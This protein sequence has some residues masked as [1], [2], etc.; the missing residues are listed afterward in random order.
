MDIFCRGVIPFPPLTVQE[1]RFWLRI[2]QEHAVFIEAGLPCD[3]VELKIE[4]RNFQTVFAEL[5]EQSGTGGDWQR[6]AVNAA[7]AV[8]AFFCFKRRILHC[9]AECRL[10]GGGLYPLFVDHLSREALYF[11]K[12]LRKP[13]SGDMHCLVDAA[14]SENIF[15]ARVVADHL[16]FVRGLV[17][18]AER[19]LVDEAR[20]LGDRF[21]QFNLQARDVA[22][23]VWHYRP[24]N[25]FIRFERDF[26]LAGQ[27][28]LAFA[29]AAGGHVARCDAVTNIPE[30]LADHVRREGEHFLAVLELIRVYLLG[31]GPVAQAEG[32][33]EDEDEE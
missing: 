16:K 4:A 19:G 31:G 7:G 17:D 24:N 5:G 12:L 3:A 30:L 33:C 25:D 27:E 8:R 20:A 6:L 11:L 22:S 13:A 23:M 15:W 18:P 28:A 2:M 29:A 21:D 10:A 1:L 9:L 26:R 14:A 32:E